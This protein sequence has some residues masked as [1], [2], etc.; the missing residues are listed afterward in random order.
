MCGKTINTYQKHHQRPCQ[1]APRMVNSK[2][3]KVPI[4]RMLPWKLHRSRQEVF[5]GRGPPAFRKLPGLWIL[6]VSKGEEDQLTQNI[7]PLLESSRVIQL[8]KRTPKKPDKSDG[9]STSTV[10]G[11]QLD[12]LLAAAAQVQCHGALC[13]CASPDG[14][15]GA[16]QGGSRALRPPRLSVGGMQG[17]RALDRNKNLQKGGFR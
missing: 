14:R 10:P 8:S 2:S 5:G 11:L 9:T 3:P 7:G 15:S 16:M 17:S 4:E 1:M 13:L 12:G 6:A